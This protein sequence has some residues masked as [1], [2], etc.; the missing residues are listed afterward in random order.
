VH[1]N[2]IARVMEK[3]PKCTDWQ[4]NDWHIPNEVSGSC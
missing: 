1:S 4:P 2:V 3:N